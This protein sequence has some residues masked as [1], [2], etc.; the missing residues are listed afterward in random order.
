VETGSGETS[1]LSL[2]EDSS[3]PQPVLDAVDVLEPEVDLQLKDVNEKKNVVVNP[4]AMGILCVDQQ[5]GCSSWSDDFGIKLKPPSEIQHTEESVKGE[6][7][8]NVWIQITE[9]NRCH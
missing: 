2:I 1:V 7:G 5:P 6:D 9:Q 3:D 4:Q 8:V